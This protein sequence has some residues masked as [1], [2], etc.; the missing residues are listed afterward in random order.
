M[1]GK[2]GGGVGWGRK[3]GGHG[4]ARGTPIVNQGERE[5]EGFNGG[6]VWTN[7]LLRHIE[8]R[9]VRTSTRA[10]G[11]KNSPRGDKWDLNR[12]PRLLPAKGTSGCCCCRRCGLFS[13]RSSAVGGDGE[14]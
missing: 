3:L 2:K 8:K 1:G 6:I 14:N 11:D 4:W 13:D 10:G 7:R 5:R 12:K 9:A